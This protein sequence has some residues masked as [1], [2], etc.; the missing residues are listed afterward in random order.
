MKKLFDK[1]QYS[2][3]LFNKLLNIKNKN[4]DQS[5][6]N[7]DFIFL[8]TPRQPTQTISLS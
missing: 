6:P 3:H 7:E 4:Q 2:C 8:L 5:H 1:Y